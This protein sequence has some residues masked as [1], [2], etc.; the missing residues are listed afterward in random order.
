M[1]Q[2]LG[3]IYKCER[4]LLLWPKIL[5]PICLIPLSAYFFAILFC[6][7]YRHWIDNHTSLVS[8]ECFSLQRSLATDLQSLSMDICKKQFTY[9]ERIRQQKEGSGNGS[10]M[11]DD[12]GG[13]GFSEHQMAKLKIN[14]ALTEEREREIQQVAQPAN[15]LAQIMK[16]LMTLVIEQ[17][18]INIL[19]QDRHQVLHHALDHKMRNT[20]TYDDALL[21]YHMFGRGQ[22]CTLGEEYQ[23]NPIIWF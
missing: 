19:Q 12:F 14:K 10:Q 2:M 23:E 17:M 15:D 4:I 22:F 5:L 18:A 16:D 7:S 13:M 20:C 11:E 8:S 21:D 3:K 9:L 1:I 6:A